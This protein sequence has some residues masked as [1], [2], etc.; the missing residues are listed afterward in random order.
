MSSGLEELAGEA[1][2]GRRGPT[3]SI[4]AGD[5]RRRAKKRPKYICWRAR[6]AI[7]LAELSRPMTMLLLS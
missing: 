4:S 7:L 2:D 1:L 5:L 6:F 3:D